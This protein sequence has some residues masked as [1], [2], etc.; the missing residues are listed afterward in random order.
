MDFIQLFIDSLALGS[1]YSVIAI[2]FSLIYTTGRFFDLSQGAAFL[3]GGYGGYFSKSVL[4][5]TLPQSFLFS[6]ICAGFF[7]MI[8]EKI[9]IESLRRK[10]ANPLVCF[11]ATLGVLI[12]IESVLSIFFGSEVKV[13]QS[14]PSASFNW[15]SIQITHT[16]LSEIGLFII[17]VPILLSIIQWTIFGRRLRAISDNQFLAKTIGIPVTNIFL[18]VAVLASSLSGI[19]GFVYSFE[20]TIDPT[21]G[22]FV[23]LSAIIASIVGGVDKVSSAILGAFILSFLESIVVIMFPSEWKHA[24][25]YTIFILFLSLRPHGI[26][27]NTLRNS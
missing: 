9:L 1:V 2:G 24:I 3:I 21:R 8:V 25:V 13:F 18:I 11:I 16:Q 12:F 17:I 5:W 23:V 20:R 6:I 19:G 22:L 26:F 10:H 7:G 27:G 4:G 15:N 14:G